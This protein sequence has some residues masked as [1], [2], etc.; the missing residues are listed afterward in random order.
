MKVLVTGVAGFIGFHL[1]LQLLKRGDEVIGIDNINDYYDV[2]LKYGRLLEL[3]IG[4]MAISYNKPV[5]STKFPGFTFIKLDISDR[6]NIESFFISN[7]IDAVVNLAAQAGVRYSIVN[8]YSYIDSNI[9]GF[10]NILEGCRH[11]GMKHLVYA[12]SSSMYG[13][14]TRLPFL[15]TIMSTTQ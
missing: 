3:G 11:Q 6:I 4:E 7:R 13:G 2:T 12:S 8:P 1:S 5:K 10:I 15:S 14:N 9:T